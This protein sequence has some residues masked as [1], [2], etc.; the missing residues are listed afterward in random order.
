[1]MKKRSTLKAA[2]AGAAVLGAGVLT[3]T[4]TMAQSFA[5]TPKQAPLSG[6]S[7]EYRMMGLAGVISQDRNLKQ[8]TW[9]LQA[10]GLAQEL[11]MMGP[12][13]VLAPNDDAF[14]KL[15][16]GAMDDLQKFE[17]R[18]ALRRVLKQHII[19]GRWTSGDLSAMDDKSLLL[20]LDGSPLKLT[21]SPRTRFNDNV[22]IIKE[23]IPAENGVI[24]VIDAV[25]LPPMMNDRPNMG[26]MP[27]PA[28]DPASPATPV[29]PAPAP[30]TPAPA[31]TTPDPA[32][33]APTNPPTPAPSPTTPDPET[34]NL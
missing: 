19:L 29:T 18:E 26:A 24:H 28:T 4:P 21:K 32:T 30:A 7:G 15:P 31:P 23:D 34:P 5:Y 25:I 1:M 20:T 3:A 13:T 22:N 27:R 2:L 33:P 11:K 6:W 14:S 9:A 17:N 12:Y 16:A 8:L 10:T